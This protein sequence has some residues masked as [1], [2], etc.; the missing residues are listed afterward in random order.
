MSQQLT[1]TQNFR[2][3]FLMRCA[4]EGLNRDQIHERVKFAHAITDF[5]KKAGELSD[6]IKLPGQVL[7]SASG[8]GAMGLAAALGLSGV[9]GS[10]LGYMAAKSQEQSVDPEEAK[11]HELMA[12]YKAQAERIRRKTQQMSYRQ[13]KPRTPQLFNGDDNGF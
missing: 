1:P 7:Q 10:G 8:Y 2:L 13:P 6:L 9:A 11:R 5:T 12:A 3:G 4:D